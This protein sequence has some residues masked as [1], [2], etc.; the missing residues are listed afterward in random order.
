VLGPDYSVNEDEDDEDAVST[1]APVVPVLIRT[2]NGWEFK[3]PS[4]TIHPAGE[5]RPG[6]QPQQK[7]ARQ[8]DWL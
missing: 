6:Q 5:T 2:L 7:G 4:R 1:L 8:I 3:A